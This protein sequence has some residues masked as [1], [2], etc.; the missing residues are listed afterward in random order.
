MHISQ[1]LDDCQKL[2]AYPIREEQSSCFGNAN[3]IRWTI[4]I[5]KI[6]LSVIGIRLRFDLLARLKFFIDIHETFWLCFS[7]KN[8]QIINPFMLLGEIC[9]GKLS[10]L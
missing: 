9:T 3:P 5:D 6:C 1:R 10:R 7:E 8:P 4:D 2:K